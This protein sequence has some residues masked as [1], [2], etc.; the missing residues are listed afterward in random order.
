[1]KSI[2]VSETGQ[3]VNMMTTNQEKKFQKQ[4]AIT[5]AKKKALEDRLQNCIEF[6]N[7]VDQIMIS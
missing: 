7:K 6:D 3:I 4:E 2:Q 1:M 5:N